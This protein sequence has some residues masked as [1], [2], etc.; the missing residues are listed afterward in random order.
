MLCEDLSASG[1]YLFRAGF[2]QH[3]WPQFW[4]LKLFN[5]RGDVFLISS[6]KER[7]DYC[8]KKRQIFNPLSRPIRTD[9][10][11][12]N[13]PHLFGVSLEED[14]VKAPAKACGRPP[15][16]TA[17]V[18]WGSN[19]NS[20]VRQHTSNG[21]KKS[22]VSQCVARF[23]RVIKIFFVVVNSTHSRSEHKVSVRKYFMPDFL[24]TRNFC[25]KTMTANVKS[26]AVLLNGS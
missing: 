9:F 11:C 1:D 18:L 21:L 17:L 4:V 3:S 19:S 23:E 26:P 15:L 2:P 10:S 13:S 22:K 14:S 7:V 20:D 12:W 5:K 24:Y 25:K 16:K 8:R 6:W